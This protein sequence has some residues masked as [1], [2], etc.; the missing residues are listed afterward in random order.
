MDISHL[1]DG[2]RKREVGLGS[3]IGEIDQDW[4]NSV[5]VDHNRKMRRTKGN[6]SLGRG[7]HTGDI[8]EKA[9]LILPGRGGPARLRETV[10]E[11]CI[12]ERSTGRANGK[13]GH[14]GAP[15]SVYRGPERAETAVGEYS[16]RRNRAPKPIGPHGRRSLRVHFQYISAIGIRLLE[17]TD[18]ARGKGITR[19][20]NKCSANIGIPYCVNGNRGGRIE[21]VILS[22]INQG[23]VSDTV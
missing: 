3:R 18:V 9:T 7:L 6:Q 17:E 21:I 15:C 8:G 4:G 22:C 11:V 2:Q 14:W 12:F 13:N 5:V 10:Q 16:E 19:V 23:R 1:L 20:R